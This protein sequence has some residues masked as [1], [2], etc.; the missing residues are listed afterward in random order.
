[1]PKKKSPHL[2][3]VED[4]EAL[5]KILKLKFE[6]SGYDVEIADDGQ[7]ALD[8]MAK[9]KYDLVML[10][11]MMPMVDGFEV[12]EKLKERKDKT[13]VVIT[14]NLGQPDDV[15]RTRDLGAKEFLIKSDVPVAEMV[16][17]VSKYVKK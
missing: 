1:M 6:K 4:N 11:L 17:R 15:Q 5:V 9:N 3:I 16:E 13:P 8:K 2:L 10:D 14:S 7:Q 12:L